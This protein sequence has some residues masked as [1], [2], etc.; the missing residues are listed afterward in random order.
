MNIYDVFPSKYL[1]AGDLKG[2]SF[3]LAI[4]KV[5]QEEMRSHSGMEKKLVVYFE[6]ATKG[7]VLN[8]TNAFAIADIVGTPETDAWK[9]TVVQVYPTKV[10]AFGETVDCVRVRGTNPIKNELEIPEDFDDDDFEF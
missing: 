10:K 7:L 8:K 5:E 9:G 1:S 3:D 6:K 2:K 4:A